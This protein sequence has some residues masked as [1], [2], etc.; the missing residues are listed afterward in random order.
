[1]S[2]Q[3]FILA[4]QMKAMF[5][6]EHNTL[7]AETYTISRICMHHDKTKYQYML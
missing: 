2:L 6:H 4:C 1:M 7:P 3:S 5:D